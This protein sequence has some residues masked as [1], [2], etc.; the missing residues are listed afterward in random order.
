MWMY[1]SKVEITTQNTNKYKC[2][3]WLSGHLLVDMNINFYV[4]YIHKTQRVFNKKILL[5]QSK[6]LLN[7]HNETHRMILTIL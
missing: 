3:N 6:S 7:T 1:T 4:N 5:N 2:A